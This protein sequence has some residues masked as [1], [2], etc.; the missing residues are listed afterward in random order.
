METRANYVTVGIFTL[1][2]ILAAFGFVYWSSGIG[3]R[4][5][6]ALLR[7]R[8]P[9]SASGLARG[10][11][12]YF[13]GV[14]VGEVGRVYIDVS[15]PNVAIADTRVDRNT[16]ITQSTRVDLGIAGLTGQ[17]NISLTGADL[18]EP[19][20]LDVAEANDQIAVI[21]ANPSAVTNLLET[22][23]D[24]FARADAV[25]KSL[26]G[27]VN[28]V[29]GPLQQ[30]AQNVENFSKALS[31]NSSNINQ[32]MDDARLIGERL[33]Q[34][35]ERLNNVL[36][37]AEEVLGGEEADGV[38]EDARRTLAAVRE[39]AES[40]NSRV[41]PITDGLT[42]FSGQGLRDFEALI[43]ES[44]RSI[45][46]IERAVTDLE[47]NP[48]RIITGGEGQVREYDGRTRR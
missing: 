30:T 10:S 6:S 35:S 15:N 29:R 27:F 41:A 4:G 40:I 14:K 34:A 43:Q 38:I 16:P 39:T 5:E 20:L 7:V 19:N 45:T 48:Q 31:D 26:E 3:D 33:T 24:I 28:N 21:S 25:L 2:A 17:S 11:V 9:G 18:N 37:R 44:R 46:R 36:A 42:R 32:F 23:Q 12:V 1:V 47:K 13:N 22:A 8:I